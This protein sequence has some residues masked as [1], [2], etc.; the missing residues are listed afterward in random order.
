MAG[1]PT[2][3]ADVPSEHTASERAASE[4]AASLRAVFAS[5]PRPTDGQ[6]KPGEWTG[7][8]PLPGT[9]SPAPGDPRPGAANPAT[10]TRRPGAAIPGGGNVRPGASGRTDGSAPAGGVTSGAGDARLG[11]MRPAGVPQQA[12]PQA[13]RG[14]RKLWVIPAVVAVGALAGVA[15]VAVERETRKD[16]TATFQQAPAPVVPDPRP[17]SAGLAGSPIAS[18]PPTSTAPTTTSPS[19]SA[20]A[21]PGKANKSGANLALHAKAE[22]S[23]VE[24]VAWPAGDAVDGS[25]KSRWSSAFADPQWIRVD[26]GQ[27]WSITDVRLEWEHAYA[28]KYRVDVSL[29]AR[30]W[31]TVYRTSSGGYG[32][33]DIRLD[34]TPARYVRMY[35]TRRS[36]QYGY[37]LL[38]FEVR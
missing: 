13:K 28:V 1:T 36:G 10:G 7:G 12:G 18:G 24:S 25:L 20:S 31:T 34:P 27:V 9:T 15:A 19:P 29:D 35:G 5:S 37:S 26:L 22:A 32:T 11:G 16:H 8:I 2:D 3:P 30:R 33:R 17:A 14:R 38:E 23:S 6:R 4:R 21:S